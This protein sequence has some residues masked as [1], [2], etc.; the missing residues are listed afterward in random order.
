MPRLTTPSLRPFA[1]TAATVFLLLPLVQCGR[2]SHPVARIGDEWIGQPEW[3]AYQQAQALAGHPTA[4]AGLVRQEVAW[5]LAQRQGLLKGEAWSDFVAST[6]RGLLEKAYLDA[7]PGPPPFTEAQAKAHYLANAEKRRVVHLVCKEQKQ[8]EAALARIRR[9]ESFEKV[10]MAV[11]IDPSKASNQGDLGWIRRDQVIQPFAQAVFAAK[12]GEV[13]GPFKTDYGWHL[14]VVREV[15]PAS[16]AD[17][18]KN[19][20]RILEDMAGLNRKLKRPLLVN[21][22]RA[23]YPLKDNQ[24]VLSRDRTTEVAPGDEK[25]IAGT[26][27]GQAITL[28]D[29]KTF[30]SDYL[31]V[32]GQSHELGPV[33]KRSFLEIMG[34]SI[35]FARAAQ[36]A[37][38]DRRPEVRAQI[39]EA[40]HLGALGA[41]SRTYLAGL[42]VPEATLQAHHDQFP[43]RFRGPGALKVYLL[44]A[45]DASSIQHAGRL[46]QQGAPWKTL[47]D[48]YA[49]RAATGNW[50]AGWLQAASLEK[51][52]P[53]EVVSAMLKRPLGSLIGPVAT[54][55]GYMLFKVLDRKPGDVLALKDCRDEVKQDYLKEHGEELVDDYL[56]AGGRQGLRIK[57]FPKNTGQAPRF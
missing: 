17:F 44:V 22:L 30:L 32:S 53:M 41:F 34:D 57:T 33:I 10:A 46:A 1:M 26:V 25:L 55:D 36:E 49:D 31:K 39:W 35:R 21:A 48:K 29:L 28:K 2:P 27:A 38:L 20:A 40:E 15:Q 3:A 14:A 11:S 19:K 4:L 13:C 18:E 7:Q 8:A 52:L 43:D 16:E 51:V 24:E 6:R 9:G 23:K 50:D 42:Q 37:K 56:N 12:P 47:F 5:M 45:D 54:P